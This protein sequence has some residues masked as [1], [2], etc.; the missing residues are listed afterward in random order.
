V[1][2]AQFAYP[3][4]EHG[5]PVPPF[6]DFLKASLLTV[7]DGSVWDSERL[8]EALSIRFGLTPA[9]RAELLPSGARPR[10]ID[11]AIWSLTYLY[12]ASLMSKPS[13]GRYVIT[14]AGMA[15]AKDPPEVLNK[16]F[17][18][19]QYPE[20]A[21]FA[22]VAG[23]GNVPP[24]GGQGTED[25]GLGTSLSPMERLEDAFDELEG[26]LAAE[27]L[28]RIS[29]LKPAAFE[30]V[31][32]HLLRAMGYAGSQGVVLH[33]GQSGD[34]GIDGIV[35]QDHLGLERVYVQ[36]KNWEQAVPGPELSKFIGAMD[37]QGA[38]KGVFFSRSMFTAQARKF[39]EDCMKRIILVDG[40]TLARLM[41]RF[42]T[43]VTV[44]QEYKVHRLDQDYFEDPG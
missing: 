34:E 37:L 26:L 7:T 29:R 42:G 36:A 25:T 16:K 8:S 23:A 4:K 39:A 18:Q 40:Q 11:R 32:L 44:I 17:L 15:L 30:R 35:S 38:S 6:A 3:D 9:D 33:T 14:E 2:W 28:D 24:N 22:T 41:I 19:E 1:R 20:F 10:Y 13:R 21:K 12:Q 43:G 5:M 27:L 31:V